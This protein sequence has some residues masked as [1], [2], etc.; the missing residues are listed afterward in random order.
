METFQWHGAFL[1]AG[2]IV[3]L[4]VF[5]GALFRPLLPSSNASDIT[6]TSNQDAVNVVEDDIESSLCK[7]SDQEKSVSVNNSFV[8]DGQSTEISKSQNGSLTSTEHNAIN[9][10][11][12]AL[13]TIYRIIKY[14]QY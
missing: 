4:N 5:F 6:T 9:H 3:L 2:A 7:L 1:I 11:V 13:C 12:N 8:N 14:L 10:P